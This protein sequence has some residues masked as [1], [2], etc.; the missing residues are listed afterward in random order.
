MSTQ[1]FQKNDVMGILL[2]NC[3]SYILGLL[4][5]ME[6]GL[7]VTTLNPAYTMPEVARQLEMSKAKII[8]TEESRVAAVKEAMNQ[9]GI[10]P[11]NHQKCRIFVPKIAT[12]FEHKRSSLRSQIL[13]LF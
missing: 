8:L 12:N 10:L 4:G 2:P 3:T 5:A 9:I 1:G 11:E 13:R 6:A 7:T